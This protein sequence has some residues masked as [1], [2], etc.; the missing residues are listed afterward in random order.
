MA[1]AKLLL[2][3]ICLAFIGR[4]AVPDRDLLRQQ[5]DQILMIAARQ[6]SVREATGGNDG[7]Q[8]EA[9]LN[10]VGFKKGDPWCAAFVSWVFKEAG[11][12]QP[13]TAWSPDLF[14]ARYCVKKVIP[15]LV[16]GI[17]FKELG[18]IGH[19]GIVTATRHNWVESIEGN[20]NVMGSR[21]GDGVYRKLRHVKTIS[22]F[23][24]WRRTLSLR[25]AGEKHES[26][27]LMKSACLTYLNNRKEARDVTVH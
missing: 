6:L 19:C 7:K 18:R 23:A 2:G 13:K 5:T 4:S 14:P 20:T 12:D 8:V 17:Y 22:K 11:Y 26:P 24:E 27:G 25:G 15:G 10:Y 21:E 1:T 3:I 9:Y 16:L